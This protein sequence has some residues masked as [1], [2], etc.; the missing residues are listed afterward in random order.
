M[1]PADERKDPE[2]FLG[3]EAENKRG[4]LK[5]YLGSAAGVGKT[6]RMLEDAHY[7]RDEG[8]D[9][10]L[11][12]IE[13]HGRAETQ[14]RIGNLEV[15]PP[16]QIAYRDV[17]LPEL[18]VDAV[19]ARRPEYAVVDELA[20][21]NA[22]GSRHNKRYQDVE[23]L[24]AAGIN[25]ITALNVQHLESL[26]QLVRRIT[27]IEVRETVPD[28]FLSKAD[29]V[30]TVDIPVEELRERLREG[31]IYPPDQ[32][33]QA[34][35]NFFRPSNLAALRELALRE[36]ARDQSRH[37]ELLELLKREGGRTPAV[38]ERLMVCLSSNPAGSE[39]LLR[40]AARSAA[41]LNADWFA[42]HVETPAESVQRIS[43]A[44]FRALLDNINLAAD[45][46]AE[47]AWLK[48]PDVIA[49]LLEFAHDKQITR[50]VIG[51][52]HRTLM[53]RVMG[54]SMTRRI[55]ERAADYDIEIARQESESEK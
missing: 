35:K 50:I 37:R 14:A 10:V 11:A 21:T 34:L 25:V 28:T 41:A 6:Y 31:K 8:H 45:L 30:V 44:N 19:L 38:T 40:R 22:P 2:A 52:T 17:V 24:V 26:N 16:R 39:G 4:R 53:R 3:L 32:V 43:T 9:V 48:A 51:R 47:V 54:Y 7:L 13:T 36:V 29:Q 33:E 23:E 5:I 18:D 27:G 12:V 46:G 49:A 42:V 1:K 20:H 15:I 55:I